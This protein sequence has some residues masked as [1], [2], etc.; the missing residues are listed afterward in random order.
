[1]K[2]GSDNYCQSSILEIMERI[3][4]KGIEVIVYE[5]VLADLEFL[6]SRVITD[7]AAFKAEADIILANRLSNEVIDVVDKVFTRDLYGDN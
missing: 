5:P 7:L 2:A 6:K 3:Q 4:S 1:M